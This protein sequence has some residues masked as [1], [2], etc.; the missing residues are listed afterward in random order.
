MTENEK[1]SLTIGFALSLT[2]SC[3]V[4]SCYRFA[5]NTHYTAKS[6]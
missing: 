1:L 2:E 6:L 5:I 3:A 4:D